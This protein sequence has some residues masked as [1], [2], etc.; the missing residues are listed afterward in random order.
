MAPAA[1]ELSIQELQAIIERKKAQE[2][3]EQ[4][5]RDE[6]QKLLDPSRQLVPASPS[7]SAYRPC[8]YDLDLKC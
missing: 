8:A 4:Q 5:R 2:N 6:Q 1:E 7:P 3:E